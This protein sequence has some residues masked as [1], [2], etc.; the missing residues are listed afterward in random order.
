M[1]TI[2]ERIKQKRK[3]LNLTLKDLHNITNISAG[4][5]SEIENSK[6]SP[7]V[8]ALIQ[9]S[10]ALNCTTDWLLTGSSPLH[11]NFILANED[12]KMISMYI[13]LDDRDKKD[14]HDFVTLKYERNK[15]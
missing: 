14:I 13:A 6:Y 3:A 15:R 8:L 5:L 2:G 9:L 4:N 12:S 10:N 1:M 11:N 7:S